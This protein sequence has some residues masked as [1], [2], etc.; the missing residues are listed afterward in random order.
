MKPFPAHPH[1]PLK[2]GETGVRTSSIF[3]PFFDLRN[4]AYLRSRSEAAPEVSVFLP[5]SRAS[6]R[7]APLG[8]GGAFPSTYLVGFR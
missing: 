6:L 8:A 7:L 1:F 4:H 3:S 2:Y 5:S